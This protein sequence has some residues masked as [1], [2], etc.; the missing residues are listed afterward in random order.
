MGRA[1]RVFFILFVGVVIGWLSAGGNTFGIPGVSTL[2]QLLQS[3]VGSANNTITT[4]TTTY[5]FVLKNDRIFYKGEV[6]GSA[7]FQS[8]IN[9][10]KQQD[11]VVVFEYDTTVT[12]KFVD[13]LTKILDAAG[14]KY[15]GIS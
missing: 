11:V 15:V 14:V 8:L 3:G 4:S 5:H 2:G 1:L 7:Q 13:E 9:E 6:I 12:G 10:A